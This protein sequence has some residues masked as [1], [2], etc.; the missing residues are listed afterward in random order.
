[1]LGVKTAGGVIPDAKHTDPLT[2]EAQRYAGIK[3]PCVR[4][5]AVRYTRIL[6][7]VEYYANAIVEQG[8]VTI[9]ILAEPHNAIETLDAFQPG[10]L[11]TDDVKACHRNNEYSPGEPCD[12]VETL[13]RRRA[14]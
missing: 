12:L 10:Q 11:F 5:G 4:I 1:M 6:A 2:I 14:E 7:G 13:L 3:D 9:R 8:V